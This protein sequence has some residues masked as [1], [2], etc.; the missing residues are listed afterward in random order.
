MMKYFR[1][2]YGLSLIATV[3]AL[4]IFAL[5]A[6]VAVSLVTTG[7]NIGLQEEQGQQAFD[8][9]EAGLQKTLNYIIKQKDA[10]CATSETCACTDADDYANT[11]P[12]LGAGSFNVATTPTHITNPTTLTAA[13]VAEA[14]TPSIPVV[15]TANYASSGRIM[16]D[17]EVIEYT[18]LSLV[19]N[20]FEGCK[21]GIAGT[22]AASHVSGTRIGQKQCTI[23]STGNITNPLIPLTGVQ[24]QVSTVTELQNGWISGGGGAED[25]NEVHCTDTNNCWAVGTNGAIMQ[26]NGTSWRKVA[27]P[28]GEDLNS[29]FMID[30]TGDGVADDG[31]AVGNEDGDELILSWD[32]AT[33]TR[34]AASGS[35]PDENLNSVYCTSNTNCWAVGDEDGNEVIIRWN[36]AAW[37]RLGPFANVANENLNSVYMVSANEV[38]IVGD[39][40]PGGANNALAYRW[41]DT[42]GN[43]IVE[44][45]EWTYFDPGTDEN[46]QSV[47][48]IDTNG[49]G[50][51]EDGW[52]VGD[53]GVIRRWNTPLANQ[54][55]NIALPVGSN[56]N[57]VYCTASNNCW[58]VGDE[59]GDEVIIRWNGAAWS[60]VGPS[61]SLP[62]ENLSSV[63]MVSANDGWAVGDNGAILRWDGTSWTSFGGGRMLRWNG[64]SWTD[65][66]SSLPAGIDQTLR[67]VSMLSYA[68]GW[69]VGSPGGVASRRPLLLQWNGNA[70]TAYDSTALNIN[71]ILR[72]VYCVAGN[73]CWAVGNQ[74]TVAEGGATV[75][76]LILWWNGA[77]WARRNSSLNINQTLRGVYCVSTNDCWTV[78]SVSGGE[79]I[80]RWDGAAWNRV[81]PYA[82][83]P[84]AQLNSIFMIDT[85]G[86]G[87]ADDGW[88]VGNASGG[89]LI[90]RW[91]GATSTW[92]RVGPYAG[93]PDANL[94]SVFCTSAN[95][96]WAVGNTGT[97]I[98]WNG[99]TWSSVA[100]PTTED[101]TSIFMITATDG[102]TVGDNGTI[103]SWN[104]S[105]WSV[106]PSPAT[107]NLY[108]VYVIGTTTPSGQWEENYP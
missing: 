108:S 61:A 79:L 63:Y 27:S 6:A 64:A 62:D 43:G 78:G 56:L 10:A 34:L 16:I 104:A 58:A 100:S 22:T 107:A 49:D 26:W 24:R 103:L 72:G 91:N 53:N 88:A 67:S 9:A 13:I 77:T 18:S 42:N 50:F 73:D 37:S 3:L 75:R 94:N 11:N 95:D 71:R 17:R 45:G 93:I 85:D 41:R 31:W 46:L 35:I 101:L 84:D 55:N 74:G 44:N 57:S 36:G 60:R 97:I 99:A 12:S 81:G 92:S 8:I 29:V 52:T 82:G 15:S 33:W 68:D 83:I 21:R 47:Y 59:D 66:T 87:D 4:L 90:I 98:R 102:Q 23:I 39:D 30:T 76:P 96:C 32:G 89:E 70:W 38:W 105:Q 28:T 65:K 1:N 20:S 7:S 51:A 86:D 19:A 2:Q 25:L 14:Y 69:V 54:W 40:R 48:M 5:F 106:A 80:L